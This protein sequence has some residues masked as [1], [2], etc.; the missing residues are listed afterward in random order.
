VSARE[1]RARR[2]ALHRCRDE[3]RKHL[4]ECCGPQP[5]PA[6]EVLRTASRRGKEGRRPLASSV[7]A[8]RRLRWKAPTR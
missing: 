2:H 6:L 5:S 7:V 1:L 8:A 4:C 3:T